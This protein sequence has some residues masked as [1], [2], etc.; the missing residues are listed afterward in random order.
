MLIFYSTKQYLK[1]YV[2]K[3][4]IIEEIIGYFIE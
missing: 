4:K 1:S 3:E 2:R